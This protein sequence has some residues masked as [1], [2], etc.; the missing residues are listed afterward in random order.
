MFATRRNG[1]PLGFFGEP[2]DALCYGYPWLT[3]IRNTG[4]TPATQSL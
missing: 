2:G 1:E 4:L 3:Y